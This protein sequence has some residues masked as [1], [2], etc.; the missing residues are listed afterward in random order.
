[1]DVLPSKPIR[2]ALISVPYGEGPQVMMPLGL[3]NIAGYVKS[4]LK[5]QIEV[6]VFDF[7]DAD[8]DDQAQLLEIQKWNADAI[9]ISVYTSHVKAAVDW[10]SQLRS[11]IPNVKIFAGGPHISLNLQKFIDKWGRIFDF[12]VTGEGEVPVLSAMEAL[13]RDPGLSDNSLVNIPS[14]GFILRNGESVITLKATPLP[15]E[16]WPNPLVNVKSAK[17]RKLTFTDRKENRVRKAVA[18]TS[19]RGCPMACSFCAIIVAGKD[20]P[21]WRA[22][23]AEHL[24]LWL[25]QEYE[26]EPFEH[27]YLMDANFFVRPQRVREF[28]DGLKKKFKDVT[29]STSSTVNYIIRMEDDIPRLAEQGLRLVEMGIE[30]GSQKQLDFLNKNATVA[31]NLKAIRILQKSSIAIGLDFIMFYPDQEVSEIRDNLIFILKA[32][33]TQQEVF[34]HYLNLLILYPGTPLRAQKERE[35]NIEFD[36]DD[37]PDSE[38]LI[39]DEKV[40]HIYRLFIH[41]FVEHHLARLQRAITGLQAKIVNLTKQGASAEFTAPF[42]LQLVLLRHIP[43]K[44]LWYLTEAVDF[45]NLEIA[46]P[47]YQSYIRAIEQIERTLTPFKNESPITQHKKAV[48]GGYVG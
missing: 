33:L 24:L 35:L 44:V 18:M 17:G 21:R 27:V 47:P 40:R 4:Q 29:W 37:L 38:S 14:I 31:D 34:D 6:Q 25:E 15:P 1:M 46:V 39:K 5:D 10:A 41:D 3:M 11:L 28:S 12:C 42:R 9:G 36:H 32:R 43:F 2:L 30:S 23:G 20:G 48:E 45:S 26:R 7:S 22:C 13:I 19:S 8:P 16:E